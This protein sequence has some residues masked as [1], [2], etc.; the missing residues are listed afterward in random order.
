[1]NRL[2]TSWLPSVFSIVAV[3]T[4]LT[5]SFRITSSARTPS[6]A[7]RRTTGVLAPKLVCTVVTLPSCPRTRSRGLALS[8]RSRIHRLSS[9]S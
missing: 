7:I 8:A 2:S 6:G 3:C 4:V 5:P 1:L 9:L